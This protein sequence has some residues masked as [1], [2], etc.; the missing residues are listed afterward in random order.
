[1]LALE[2]EA[3]LRGSPHHLADIDGREA[4]EKFHGVSARAGGGCPA[5]ADGCA[6]GARAGAGGCVRLR[7]WGRGCDRGGRRRGGGRARGPAP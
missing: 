4:A 7:A 2:F 6:G 1:V 5:H 3:D